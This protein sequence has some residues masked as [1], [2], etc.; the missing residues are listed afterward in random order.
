MFNLNFLRAEIIIYYTGFW[1]N[2]IK[3]NK[4]L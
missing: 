3:T 1:I 2:K 4:Y